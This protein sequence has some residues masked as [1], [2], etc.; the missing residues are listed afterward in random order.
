MKTKALVALLRERLG[1]AYE[2]LQQLSVNFQHK[3]VKK[4]N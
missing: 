3:E 1:D 4:P 2:I